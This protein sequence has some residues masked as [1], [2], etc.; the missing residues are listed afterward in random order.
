MR[1]T[2]IF[3]LDGVLVD[4][5]AA[6]AGCI[7]H[8]LTALG[9]PSRPEA[10]LHPYIGPPLSHA[11]GELLGLAPDDP[12]VA[13]MIAAYRGRYA[14][15]SLTDTIVQ[16]GIP[17]VL[18]ELAQRRRLAVVTS[19]V[20]AFAEPLLEALGLRDRFEVVAGPRLDALAEDKAQ[21]LA[22]AL[23]A[24]GPTVAVM[25]GDRS[26][27]VL[28]AHANAVPAI[29]VAWGIGSPEELYDAGA[30]RVI[31]APAELPGAVADLLG[32]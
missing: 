3:D 23:D 18:D 24:L 25:V 27:D 7:N 4:S 30:E 16:D 1:T 13:A 6:I 8:A 9:R 5:R 12:E 20:Q 11:F 22:T 19:K 31:G 17:E 32:E 26:F 21:T 15:V 10:D 29:G 2:V 28:A 14:T